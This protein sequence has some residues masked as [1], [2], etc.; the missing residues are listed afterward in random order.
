MTSWDAQINS[1]AQ[2]PE[3]YVPN[4]VALATV[5]TWLSHVCP[6]WTRRNPDSP[7]ISGRPAVWPIKAV[8]SA[9]GSACSAGDGAVWLNAW[10]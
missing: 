1:I 6:G 9:H 3:T 4:A 5:G 7:R 10:W 2:D 8:S